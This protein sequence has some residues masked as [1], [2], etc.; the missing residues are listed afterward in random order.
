MNIFYFI[1]HGGFTMKFDAIYKKVNNQWKNGGMFRGNEECQCVI[2][3]DPTKW[4]EP[5]FFVHTCSKECYT[6]LWQLYKEK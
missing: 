4:I 1:G 2:C 5:T 3:N 6:K